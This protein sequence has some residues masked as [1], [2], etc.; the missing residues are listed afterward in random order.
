MTTNSLT[1]GPEAGLQLV[2]KKNTTTSPTT[3][4][5][6]I[7]TTSTITAGGHQLVPKNSKCCEDRKIF[8][9]PSSSMPVKLPA[10]LV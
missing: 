3:T 4:T 7:T 8:N 6:T 1:L 5:T 9:R 10:W 2:R